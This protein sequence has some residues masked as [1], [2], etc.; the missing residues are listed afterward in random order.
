MWFHNKHRVSNRRTTSL[1][2]ETDLTHSIHRTMAKFS[3][4]TWKST[5]L[6]MTALIPSFDRPLPTNSSGGKIPLPF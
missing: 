5:W 1:A 4:P 6:Y 2:K 3:H